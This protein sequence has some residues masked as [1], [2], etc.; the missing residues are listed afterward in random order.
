MTYGLFDKLLLLSGGK[1]CYCGDATGA[2]AYFGGIGHPMPNLTNPA[3]FMLRLT[4]VDFERDTDAARRTHRPAARCVDG[5]VVVVALQIGGV[6]IEV[7]QPAVA[8]GRRGRRGGERN[9]GSRLVATTV[10]LLHRSWIKSRRDVLVYGLRFGMYLGLAILIGT[11]WLRLPPA[12]GNIQPYSN[13]ILF[14]S[15][16]MS[17]MSV[18]YV[19]AFVEDRMVYVKERASS[20]YGTTAF[21]VSNSSSGCPTC[22]SSHWPARPSCIGW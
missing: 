19:P 2:Q 3:D 9:G 22:S 15:A 5:L 8:R 14:G 6:D 20:L 13:C 12:Q 18:V 7:Q 1:T 17:F 4:N 11:V 21:V 10:T 16:F